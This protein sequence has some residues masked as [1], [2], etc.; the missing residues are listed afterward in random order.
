LNSNEDSSDIP[1]NN[2]NITEMA[3]EGSNVSKFGSENLRI[4]IKKETHV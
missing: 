1:L 4:L 3:I 2:L